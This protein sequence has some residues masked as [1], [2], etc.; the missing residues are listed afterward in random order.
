LT[1]DLDQ[2]APPLSLDSPAPGATVSGGAVRL[3][4]RTEPGAKLSVQGRELSV[5]P[6]GNFSTT[7]PMPRGLTNL[8]VA[9]A[10]DLGNSRVVSRAVLRE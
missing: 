6:D 1:V 10:D 9:A 2:A 4:G 7:I 3:A 8:V 5:G